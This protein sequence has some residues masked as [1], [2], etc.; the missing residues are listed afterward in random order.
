VN[1][2]IK[3]RNITAQK[4]LIGIGFGISDTSGAKIV[5]ALAII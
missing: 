1:D 3:A 4:Q 2:T 5:I